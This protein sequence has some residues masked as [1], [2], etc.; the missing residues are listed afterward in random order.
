DFPGQRAK[1]SRYRLR[2]RA[3]C[4][5]GRKRAVNSLYW[6]IFLAFWLALALILIGTV[7]VVVNGDQ[8]RRFTQSWTQRAE[9]YAEATQA[10]E[11]GGVTALHDW[12]K[13]R[14]SDVQALTFIVD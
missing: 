8:Q 7:S 13:A 2:T 6:R 11:T 4:A 9:L 14:P 10:F 12:L 3:G 1:C 5:H